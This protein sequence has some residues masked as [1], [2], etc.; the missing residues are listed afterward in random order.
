M[1]YH[2]SRIQELDRKIAKLDSVRRD[3]GPGYAAG[4]K[5][6]IVL[7]AGDDERDVTHLTFGISSNIDNIYKTLLEELWAARVY[8]VARAN[9]DYEEIRVFLKRDPGTTP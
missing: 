1:N 4:V 5:V 6:S 8:N 3:H 9:E 7:G 2:V